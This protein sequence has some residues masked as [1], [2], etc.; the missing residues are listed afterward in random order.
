MIGALAVDS[1]ADEIPQEQNPSP[2]S[3]LKFRVV[4]RQMRR[5]MLR[6]V[7]STAKHQ[8]SHEVEHQEYEEVELRGPSMIHLICSHWSSYLSAPSGLQ[9]E[10]VGAQVAME[11]EAAGVSY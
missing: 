5:D 4:V 3:T 1:I 6:N 2:D 7:G 9:K 10:L 11:A 8:E